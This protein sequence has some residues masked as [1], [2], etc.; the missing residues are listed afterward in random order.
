MIELLW[1]DLHQL[2]KELQRS[3]SITGQQQL[4]SLLAE[5]QRMV[6]LES[7]CLCESLPSFMQALFFGKPLSRCEQVCHL[8]VLATP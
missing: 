5:N 6:R 7:L 3:G 2:S 4:P 8:C 1:R